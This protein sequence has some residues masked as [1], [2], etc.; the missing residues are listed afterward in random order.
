[1]ALFLLKIVL[2]SLCASSLSRCRCKAQVRF[3]L[4][5]NHEDDVGSWNPS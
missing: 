1:V 3:V 2:C 4:R 5:M